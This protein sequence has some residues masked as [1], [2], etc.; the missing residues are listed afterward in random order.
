MAR[1]PLGPGPGA[2][3]LPPTVGYEK[4]DNRKQR[5]P[6][7]SFGARTALFGPDP[8]PGPGAYQVDKLTRHGKGGAPIYSIAPMTKIIDKR[9]GPGPGAHDVHIKPFFKGVRAPEYSMAPRND[10]SFKKY[11]PGPSAYKF[12]INPIRPAAPAYSMGISAKMLKK[13]DSPG[14]AAYGAGDINIKLNRAPQYSMRPRCDIRGENVGP[15]SNYYDLSYY[16]PGRSGGAYSFGVR[17]SPYAPPMI[18]RCD[19]M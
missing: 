3:A 7:Y 18:V 13:A 4:H 12:E 15:G 17:H 19:N 2:Y 1:M 16:R 10:Y 11:G 9:V 6:Q 5:L 14:P 8:G